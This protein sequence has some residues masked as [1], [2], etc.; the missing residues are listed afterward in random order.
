MKKTDF[1]KHT[2][3]CVIFVLLTFVFTYPCFFKAAD[4]IFAMSDAH[5]TIWHAVWAYDHLFT[6][7][8]NLFH[9]NIFYPARYTAIF[10]DPMFSNLIIFAPVYFFTKNP[11]LAYNAIGLVLMF[12]GAVSMYCLVYYWTRKKIPAFF[13]GFILAFSPVFLLYHINLPL[14]VA[15]LGILFLDKSLRNEKLSNIIIFSLIF[16]FIALSHMYLCYGMTFI[17]I[18]YIIG[19]YI[20]IKRKFNKYF[21]TKSLLGFIIILILVL[22]FR[23]PYLQLKKE[24]GYQRKLGEMVQHSADPIVS[25]FSIKSNLYNITY[26]DLM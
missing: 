5:D 12:L 13:A 11:F 1:L 26:P 24:Y 19:Y 23:L 20:K 22:P 21:Y 9:G 25:Y 18:I 16:S 8:L 14:I 3:I 2:G 6:D 4:M 17:T 15:P 7:P 10:T